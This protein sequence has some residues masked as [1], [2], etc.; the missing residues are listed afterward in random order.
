MKR[1]HLRVL[2]A[3]TINQRDTQKK[4]DPQV[5]LSG[6]ARF[7]ALERSDSGRFGLVEDQLDLA[8]SVEIDRHLSAVHEA[9]EQQ[10]IC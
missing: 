5:A 1:A 7:A 6:C 2:R 3:G 9:T 8:F 10:F 4:G